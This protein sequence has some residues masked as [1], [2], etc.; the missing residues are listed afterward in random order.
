MQWNKDNV[1]MIN[2]LITIGLETV[3]DLLLYQKRNNIHT[4][5]EL[6]AQVNLDFIEYL[7]QLRF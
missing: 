1:D 4:L 6:R 3:D 2:R 7:Y 5:E